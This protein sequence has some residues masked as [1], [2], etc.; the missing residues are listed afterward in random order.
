MRK[1]KFSLFVGKNTKHEPVLDFEV[2]ATQNPMRPRCDL[3]QWPSQKWVTRWENGNR[4]DLTNEM[5]T[6][7]KKGQTKIRLSSHC[8]QTSP[9]RFESAM[10]YLL[11]E[12]IGFELSTGR[13][14]KKAHMNDENNSNTN[15]RM[16]FNKNLLVCMRFGKHGPLDRAVGETNVMDQI[17]TTSRLMRDDAGKIVWFRT[18]RGNLMPS[19]ISTWDNQIAD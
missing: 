2:T 4:G 18:H 5:V 17:W 11:T 13:H 16:L 15:N 1:P 7:Y 9:P 14:K 6:L 19:P 3:A 12:L 8:C 10:I